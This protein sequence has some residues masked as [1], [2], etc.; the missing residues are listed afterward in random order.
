MR[1]SLLLLFVLLG[2]AA[3]A[4]RTADAGLFVGVSN[5][6]GDFALSPMSINETHVAYG[7][8][9]QYFLN[10]QWGIK[11]SLSY[12]RISGKDSNL[13]TSI[14]AHRNWSF[15]SGVLELAGH[16][17]FHPWGNARY[18]DFG[19][20]KRHVSPYVSLG[21]GLAFANARVTTP[22]DDKFL[23]PEADDRS[24]F[25]AVPISLGLRFVMTERL[26]L[27]GEIGQRA[28]FS[29]YLDGVSK[30]GNANAKDW[31]MFA[32]IGLSYTLFAE[33]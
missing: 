26:T 16:L 14:Q 33:Y 10:P 6:Q 29:D 15:E 4:Q 27:T 30:Y 18:D 7:A 22:N 13:G 20:F 11:G 21:A 9:Y 28:T 32:G 2:T 8:L 19:M 5:Y 24:V 1:Y 23:L 3:S 31:Y 25:F 17:Q 12:G